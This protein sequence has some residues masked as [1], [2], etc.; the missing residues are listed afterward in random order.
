MAKLLFR[1][2]SSQPIPYRLPVPP[3]LGVGRGGGHS[4][5]KGAIDF[6]IIGSILSLGLVT[7]KCAC[8]SSSVTPKMSVIHHPGD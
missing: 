3:L 6:A 5:L 8:L 4:G 2:V 1:P 7:S